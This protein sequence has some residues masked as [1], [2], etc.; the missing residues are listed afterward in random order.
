MDTSKKNT[1][2]NSWKKICRVGYVALISAICCTPAVGM[3]FGWGAASTE[4]RTMA[5]M[6]DLYT[7]SEGK[8]HL[9]LN[10]TSE[11]GEYYAEHF[12]FRQELVTA[13]SLLNERIFGR[14][15]GDKTVIGR[16]GWY[17]LSETVKD[18]TGASALSE[19]GIYRLQ[20]TLALMDQYAAASNIT[21]VFFAAPNKCSIYPQF[22]PWH[23]RASSSPGNLDRLSQSMR[24]CPYYI[25]MKEVLQEAAAQRSEYLYLKNDSHWNNLGALLAYNAV[26][27]NLNKRIRHYD[28]CP[29]EESG[30]TMAR[31]Q[32]SGDLTRMLYPALEVT[33]VQYN[34]GISR[35][36]ASQKP[37]TNLMDAEI[38]TTCQGRYYNLLC[39]RDSFFNAL[40]PIN[41]NAFAIARYARTSPESS[42]D[43][44]AVRSGDFNIALVEI[45]ERNLTDILYSAPI[46]DAPTV[47]K[48]QTTRWR[49]S[50]QKGRLEDD[51]ESLLISGE[52][53]GWI[54]L[55]TESNIYLELRSENKS[56]YFEAF[57][58]DKGDSYA[59]N[60]F[61]ARISKYNLPNDEYRMLIHVGDENGTVYTELNLE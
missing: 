31:A 6:P 27:D 23:L 18:Y 17:Y 48:P 34:L 38:N 1:K 44:N 5:G 14:S 57:P 53:D 33:D 51:G 7:A 15:S 13:D 12:G 39:Y 11:L 29:I 52:I 24:G 28:Y 10:Y 54:T 21:F 36:F 43:M 60:G 22:M 30:L 20:K 49:S 37:L 35:A 56:Y 19:R 3:L 42:Y 32:V 25:D 50:G 58:I 61:S 4:N 2:D 47:Q 46:M 41:S 26:Q 55:D 9:N 45:A 40:I 8:S 16:E 59:D